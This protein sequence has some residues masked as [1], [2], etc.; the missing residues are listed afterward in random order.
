MNGV[1]NILDARIHRLAALDDVV[2]AQVG[3]DAGEA[4]A[5]GHGDHAVFLLR[6]LGLGRF[7]LLALL[8]GLLLGRL[9]LG[10]ALAALLGH[11]VDLQVHQI[12]H[13]AGPLNGLARIVG[14]H[15]HL[16]K[17]KVAH[18]DHAVADAAQAR[19][20]LVDVVLGH[21]FVHVLNDEF[22][23]V[24]ER[25]LLERVVIVL[26]LER[27]RI[28][29]ACG[30]LLDLFAVVRRAPALE[31]RQQALSAGVDHARLLERREHVRRLFQNGLAAADHLV[32][33]LG[34]GT[35]LFGHIALCVLSNH[36]DD[37]E[38]GALLGLHDRLVRGVRAG[39]QAPGKR[40]RVDGVAALD[41]AGEA[42]QDL[43]ED[44]AGVAA[45][46][47]ERAARSQAGQLGR[48]GDVLRRN[49]LHRGFHRQG[50]V[51]ARVAVRHGEHVQRVDRLA[52]LFK[53][54]RSCDNHLFQKQPV[55]SLL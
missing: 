32:E 43:G 46:A 20:E 3:E 8:L 30:R 22:R 48:A 55:N 19:A 35:R 54:V 7:L 49:L 41:A 24:L 50:H 34:H 15:M 28:A 12:A 42:A 9:R 14:V 6:L 40:L 10:Q 1:Q 2:H 11:V 5:E 16:D 21:A 37:G 36:A 44:D 33:H 39:A 52:V 25:Q 18:A 45:R 27:R 31:D 47:L 23:T 53:Q 29:H 4:L 13:G 17:L 51:G 26:K 38:D